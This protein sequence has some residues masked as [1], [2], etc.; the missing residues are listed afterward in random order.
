MN[1]LDFITE[2]NNIEGEKTIPEKELPIY[3]WFL[4]K[5]LTEDRVK[6]FHMDLF[7]VRAQVM[8]QPVPDKYLGKYRDVPVYIGSKEIS[9]VGIDDAMELLFNPECTASAFEFHKIFENI[10][11]FIDGNGRVGRAI[12]RHQHGE[13]PL[14]FLH[15]YYYQSLV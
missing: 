3:E 15:T 4:S 12:W 10:H 8:P 1:L 6:D 7:A 5:E 2:S 14:G 9:P 11:P 13:A